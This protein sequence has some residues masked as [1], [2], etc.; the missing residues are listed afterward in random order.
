MCKTLK[1][2]TAK[3]AATLI[4]E[5][6]VFLKLPRPK[7]HMSKFQSFEGQQATTSAKGTVH[8]EEIAFHHTEVCPQRAPPQE[9]QCTKM[10]RL[11]IYTS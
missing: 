8:D 1:T 2:P 5:Q 11:K 4:S 6:S 9:H 10:E 3:I 7:S